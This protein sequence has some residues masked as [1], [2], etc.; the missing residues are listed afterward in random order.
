MKKRMMAVMLIGVL[1]LSTGCGSQ[2]D[3]TS[4]QYELMAEYVSGIMLKR[5]HE[6]KYKYSKLNNAIEQPTQAPT[7]PGE[8]ESETAI[9]PKPNEGE[10]ETATQAPNALTAIANVLGDGVGVKYNKYVIGDKYPLNPGLGDVFVSA[11]TDL[12]PAKKVF[13]V[14]FILDNLTEE[15]IKCISRG[16]DLIIGISINGGREMSQMNTLLFNDLQIMKDYS[17][18]AGK[19]AIGVACFL[20]S[21]TELENIKEFELFVYVNQEKKGSVVIK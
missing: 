7:K 9:N 11:P 13:T 1:L 18:E 15:E 21:E 2:L 20:I 19:Q 5:S 6:Y 8:A 4:E 17:V 10:S 16:K 12:T 14:E 3:V